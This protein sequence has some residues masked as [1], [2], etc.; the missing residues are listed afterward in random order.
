MGHV[1]IV[2]RKPLTSHSD[3]MVIYRSQR[4]ASFRIDGLRSDLT[5]WPQRFA[6]EC[7]N[8]LG[9]NLAGLVLVGSAARGDFIDGFS[10]LD[11]LFILRSDD[12]TIRRECLH[13]IY[14]LKARCER[15][16]GVRY[17]INAFSES[18]LF[19]TSRY[20]RVSPLALHEFASSNVV[21]YGTGIEGV[22]LP[23]SE[24]PAVRGFAVGDIL[25]VRSIST[26]SAIPLHGSALELAVRR[27]I[28]LT[29]R[30]AKAYLATEGELITGKDAILRD[31]EQIGPSSELSS[32]LRQL[33]ETRV[34]WEGVRAKRALLFERYRASIDFINGLA[35]YVQPIVPE[36]KY[37]THAQISD[38]GRIH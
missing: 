4:G 36:R 6:D 10:D 22:V 8:L 19:F 16:E 32:A 9:E 12:E 17:G 24:D 35:D 7:A 14:G 25:E 15:E 3:E 27:A 37:R 21:L 28:W 11:F 18:S 33:H 1:R 5:A 30:A 31:F 26:R 38:L 20:P 2:H 29:F 23:N 34:Y 13:R